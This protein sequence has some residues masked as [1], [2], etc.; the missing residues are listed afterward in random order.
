MTITIPRRDQRAGKGGERRPLLASR[1]NTSSNRC[2]RP[3]RPVNSLTATGS[4]E[5]LGPALVGR[6]YATPGRPCTAPRF[7]LP[8]G[9]GRGHAMKCFATLA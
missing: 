2:D 9:C 5:A 7:N 6:A 3:A 4:L 1:E 8:E